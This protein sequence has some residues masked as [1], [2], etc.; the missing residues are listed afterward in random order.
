[1]RRALQRRGHM[2]PSLQWK[3][4]PS[5]TLS[6]PAP[7]L[8]RPMLTQRQAARML[9]DPAGPALT[10]RLAH[11]VLAAGFAGEPVDAGAALLYDPER[12]RALAA[13]PDA[14]WLPLPPA[15]D[16]GLL[17]VRTTGRPGA[18]LLPEES[19]VLP[20]PGPYRFSPW[21]SLELS[22]LIK[23]QGFVPTVVTVASYVLATAQLTGLVAGDRTPRG[24][25]GQLVLEPAGDWRRAFAGCR[26]VTP[27]G[28]PWLLWTPRLQPF[29]L[30]TRAGA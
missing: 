26:L 8:G 10:R 16:A 4:T 2:S 20:P 5:G 30:L 9:Q 11:E 24:R 27:P 22:L 6:V 25:Q 1:M 13:L 12:V 18:M 23:A 21:A 3:A 19:R 15:C 7:S 14:T 29:A 17:V 28:N